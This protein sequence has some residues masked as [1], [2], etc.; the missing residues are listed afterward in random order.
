MSEINDRDSLSTQTSNSSS[1][2]E[3]SSSATDEEFYTQVDDLPQQDVSL[4]PAALARIIDFLRNLDLSNPFLRYTETIEQATQTGDVESANESELLNEI[5]ANEL[6]NAGIQAHETYE[7]NNFEER[8]REIEDEENM[9]TVVYAEPAINIVEASTQ[10]DEVDNVVD[11]EADEADSVF[12]Y[13]SDNLSQDY[14]VDADY[15]E[16]SQAD[17]T[18]EHRNSRVSQNPESSMIQDSELANDHHDNEMG[19]ENTLESDVDNEANQ[20][21]QITAITHTITSTTSMAANN[22]PLNTTMQQSLSATQAAISP[23]G[24][25]LV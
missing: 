12:L 25:P 22:E 4:H 6:H 7:V 17:Y 2:G 5:D 16:N 20:Q 13:C 21:T 10:T 3:E 18:I 24:L 11:T 9:N 15:P 23:T 1:F 19:S 14:S 8:E